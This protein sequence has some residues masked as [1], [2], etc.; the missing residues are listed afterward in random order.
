[1]EHMERERP[2]A[3]PAARAARR[4]VPYWDNVKF[5]LIFLV[6]LGHFL[7][8]REDLRLAQMLTVGIYTF[9]MPAFAFVSGYLS[10]S[11]TKEKLGQKL[12]QLAKLVVAYVVFNGVFVLWA[13]KS[14]SDV[15]LIHP[16]YSYWY[17]MALCVWRL[18]VGYVGSFTLGLPLSVLAALLV[19]FWSDAGNAFAFGRTIAFYPFFLA[20]YLMPRAWGT[21]LAELKPKTKAI[22][23]GLLCV[24]T[25]AAI[26]G[27]YMLLHY[28][29]GHVLMDPYA[30]R[31]D[32]VSR[33]AILLV[34]C[35]ATVAICVAT[36]NARIPLVTTIGRNSLIVYLLHRYFVLVY[37]RIF[38][39][40]ATDLALIAGSL[41]GSVV[42]LVL[43]GNEPVAKVVNGFLDAAATTL[44]RTPQKGI[45]GVLSKALCA[46]MVVAVSVAPIYA[47]RSADT[48]T[49]GSGTGIYERMDAQT[50]D[51][52]SDSYT[53]LFSGDLILLE[54]QVRRAYNGEG[55]D[56]TELFTYTKPYIEAADLA[57]GVY[58]GPSAGEEAGYSSGNFDDYKPMYVNMPDEFATAVRDAGFD[59]VTTA[60]NHLLDRGEQGALRT[61]DV[62]DAAGLAHIGS[63]RS[64]EENKSERVQVIEQDGLKIAVL[65]YTYGVNQTDSTDYPDATFVGGEYAYL[66]STIVSPDSPQFAEAKN[67]VQ[68]DLARAKVL[69]CDLIV[70]LPH[71][72]M[73]LSHSADDL[74][75]TWRDIFL[76]GGADIILGDHSHVVQPNVFEEVNGKM[77]FTCYCPGHYTDVYT[78]RD[79]DAAA[80]VEVHVDRQSKQVIGASVVPMWCE[81]SMSGNFR[82]LPVYDILHNDELGREMATHD[83]DHLDEVHRIVTSVMMGEEMGLEMA[84]PR[85]TMT[86]DGFRR[87]SVDQ[88]DVTEEMGSGALAEALRNAQDVCFVG[89]DVTAGT[90]NGGYGWYEPIESQ[91]R[92]NVTRVAEGG[93]TVRTMLGKVDEMTA[94]PSDLYVVALGAN[95]VRLRDSSVC[96]MNADE[97]VARQRELVNAIRAVVPN[98]RFCFVAPWTSTSGD[99][100]TPLYIDEKTTLI[101]EYATALEE[102]AKADGHAFVNANQGINDVVNRYV[103]SDYLID[104]FQ[105]NATD[106]IAL[107]ARAAMEA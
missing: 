35:L 58:E 34:A 54:D 57:I 95:D 69:G 38:A 82:A 64:E 52:V 68:A 61:L 18:T 72:G 22:A 21:R 12:P 44:T 31:F 17:I 33:A 67:A 103:Q 19:G 84:H 77:T 26:A 24:A 74:Q 40:S 50:E 10:K 29:Y 13:A 14:G 8:C 79:A 97:Y 85:L 60:N 47:M 4:R 66:T 65:A 94:T 15:F 76:E 3:S 83:L 16:Y 41:V 32:V 51:A 71:W 39:P 92:G 102:F 5:V 45:V 75:K 88:I 23:G 1:M 55:Y 96:A 36:P 98:A 56:F 28:D 90:L 27:S 80:L 86:P 53:I 37:E 93:A 20:G 107:Y 89:D 106:G 43:L 73:M 46:L 62:L 99:L 78:G 48:T 63:Y 30:R 25:I 2:A 87:A 49:T 104:A 100:G 91:V 7:G 11:W 70:V 101:N 6:A 42:L 9:H 105:P 59:L 81:S